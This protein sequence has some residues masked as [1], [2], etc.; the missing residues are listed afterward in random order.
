MQIS[1]LSSIWIHSQTQQFVDGLATILLTIVEADDNKD[2]RSLVF[3]PLLF[4]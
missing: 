4:F 3:Y 2:Q 1:A